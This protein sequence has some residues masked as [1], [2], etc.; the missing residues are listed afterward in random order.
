MGYEESG[1]AKLT[2]VTNVLTSWGYATVTKIK[3]RPDPGLKIIIKRTADFQAKYDA[4]AAV[5]AERR[6]Q[7]LKTK[8]KA[9]E[10]KPQE[11]EA[12]APEPESKPA[13]EKP[14]E[15]VSAAQWNSSSFLYSCL[16]K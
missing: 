5:L 15:E 9:E 3:T 4:F 8:E 10:K 7:R 16:A 13:E 12:P 2:Q 6:E 14:A 1:M 11:E